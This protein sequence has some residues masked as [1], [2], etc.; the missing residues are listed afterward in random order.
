MSEIHTQNLGW[1][2]WNMDL[3]PASQ[4]IFYVFSNKNQS[5]EDMNKEMATTVLHIVE[6]SRDGGL[7]YD[8]RL[9]I[10]KIVNT[11]IEPTKSFWHIVDVEWKKLLINTTYWVRYLDLCSWVL[12]KDMNVNCPWFSNSDCIEPLWWRWFM[13][14]QY[15]TGHNLFEVYIYD[16]DWNSVVMRKPETT[17]TIN[18]ILDKQSKQSLKLG[19]HSI[20][21]DIKYNGHWKYYLTFFYKRFQTDQ[22]K[23][24][25]LEKYLT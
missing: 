13:Y 19:N 15:N 14:Y 11:I 18:I 17:S 22:I 16:Y 1:V 4:E 24:H 20:L 6:T 7:S 21:Y 10:Q 3:K 5:E 12:N 25:L 2:E 8:C 23:K 9:E